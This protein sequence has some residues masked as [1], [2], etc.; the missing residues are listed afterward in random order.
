[1][2][3]DDEDPT[4]VYAWQQGSPEQVRAAIEKRRQQLLECNMADNPA[5]QREWVVL[6]G[7]R[8]LLAVTDMQE[9]R[10]ARK[11]E[12]LAERAP[13]LCGWLLKRGYKFPYAYRQR[14]FV[15]ENATGLLQYYKDKG[16]TRKPMGSIDL[17]EVDKIRSEDA[18]GRRFCL[19]TPSLEWQLQAVD[20]ETATLWM[21]EILARQAHLKASRSQAFT[22]ATNSY[23]VYDQEDE[24]DEEDEEQPR[25]S[26]EDYSAEGLLYQ[27]D[28]TTTE[29]LIEHMTGTNVTTSRSDGFG[30]TDSDEPPKPSASPTEDNNLSESTKSATSAAVS[31][32][33]HQELTQ[34]FQSLSQDN[35][36][37]KETLSLLQRDLVTRERELALKDQAIQ[38]LQA[39][40]QE[41][42]EA[43]AKQMRDGLTVEELSSRLAW[44][45]TD[46]AHTRAL[47]DLSNQRIAGAMEAVAF[48]KAMLDGAEIPPDA[49][50][51]IWLSQL[52]NAQQ[53]IEASA[54]RNQ[55]LELEIDELRRQ[56]QQRD[57]L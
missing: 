5:A 36:L 43:L 21:D 51:A 3:S 56:L 53:E 49:R 10:E 34:R 17:G 50:E 55:Q 54:D 11:Q 23:D 16:A 4:K 27:G 38:Q 9:S 6:L 1:M 7:E 14:W 28:D 39:Q 30:A 24:E 19:V 25:K 57:E 31:S 40:L 2:S 41:E 52:E 47:L 37:L 32:K 26:S 48:Y 22:A 18:T 42:K 12:L 46:L 33:A 44:S 45:Q 8:N 29:D 15:Y 20:A 13:P 35:T